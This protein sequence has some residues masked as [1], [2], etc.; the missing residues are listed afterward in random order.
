SHI[1]RFNLR[2]SPRQKG[3]GLMCGAAKASQQV[4]ILPSIKADRRALWGAPIFADNRT[5]SGALG[6]A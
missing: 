6:S 1:R 3:C 4:T 2:I 5:P